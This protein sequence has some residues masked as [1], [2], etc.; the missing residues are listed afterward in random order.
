MNY[1]EIKQKEKLVSKLPKIKV[2]SYLRHLL[3]YVAQLHK[4]IQL[5]ENEITNE[6][7]K[8]INS[9]VNCPTSKLPEWEDKSTSN[10]KKDTDPKK[11]KK[12]RKKRNGSGNKNKDELIATTSSTTKNEDCPHC[13]CNL[14][15]EKPF[16][17]ILRIVEDINDF[18]ESTNISEENQERV[19]CPQCKKKIT[20]QSEAALPKS[21]IGLRT[22][23]LLTYL[24]VWTA[25]S[26]PKLADYLDSFFN[27]T[28][29]TAGISKMMIRVG[30]ILKPVYFEILED[31]KMGA[32]IYA[33]ETGWRVGGKLHW[34][35]IFA[36]KKSAFY[37][38]DKSR[39]GSVIEKLLGTC[40]Q[41]LLISDAWH[42]YL[43]IQCEKQT[44]MSHIFRKI[45]KL[46][47]AF[48]KYYSVLQFYE[49]LKKIINDGETLQNNRKKVGEKIF[50]A[51]LK[52][53]HTRLDKLLAW[54][55]PNEI[56]LDIIKKVN[57]QRDYILTFIEHPEAESH[58]NY[59]EY[60]V[61]KGILKRKISGGST[62]FK[63][64][65][66]FSVLI[67][68]YQTCHLRKIP[69][70][71]FMKLTLVQY[72]KT[73]KPMLLSEYRKQYPVNSK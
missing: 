47:D 40:F 4:K 44:C 10:K 68:I 72:I 52:R 32:I 27:L 1:D 6:K 9:K 5:L 56:L 73:G 14:K 55:K 51:N 38:P 69:V 61:K 24:W 21:D 18:S 57:R 12:K 30:D 50:K 8:Q 43:K 23:V 34:L 66:A 59:S 31:I 42:A 22:T 17:I 26:L 48:P 29:S 2:I 3:T 67:S 65:F 37:W 36:N 60:I 54:K 16:E 53:L 49:K 20:A 7:I 46:K 15:N 63:G 39:G 62:S 28:I 25:I 45:R 71:H 11:K 41:G 19:K 35:W 70:R 64:L 13:G 58:N 33:D